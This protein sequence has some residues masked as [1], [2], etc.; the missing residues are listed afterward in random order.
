MHAYSH[1]LR[2]YGLAWLPLMFLL[3]LS[4]RVSSE[5]RSKL[6]YPLFHQVF[7]KRPL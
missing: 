6:Y 1:L 5:D 3:H 2:K 7:F 4:A